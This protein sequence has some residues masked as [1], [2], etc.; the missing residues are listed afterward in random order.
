[1]STLTEFGAGARTYPVAC[2]GVRQRN[3]IIL[4]K[5]KNVCA[6]KLSIQA[7]NLNFKVQSFD[8]VDKMKEVFNLCF[9]L[10]YGKNRY[11]KLFV[12]VSDVEGDV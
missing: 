10:I 11:S 7:E 9:F 1:L 4:Q 8:E 6:I 2:S 5:F 12:L 3:L